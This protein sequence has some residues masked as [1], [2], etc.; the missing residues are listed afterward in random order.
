MVILELIHAK[1]LDFLEEWYL[2]DQEPIR[3]GGQLVI[4][5]N[6]TNRLVR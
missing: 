3:F 2:L 6:L 4:H 1:T 5:D